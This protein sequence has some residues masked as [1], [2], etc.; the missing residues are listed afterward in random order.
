MGVILYGFRKE[1]IGKGA[2]E[3]HNPWERERKTFGIK[4]E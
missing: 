4:S 1:K 3:M 2:T